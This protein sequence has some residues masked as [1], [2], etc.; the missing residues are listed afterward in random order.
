[1]TPEHDE[2]EYRSCQSHCCVR[3]GCKYGHD[4]CPVSKGRVTQ[5]HPCE[6]CTYELEDAGQWSGQPYAARGEVGYSVAL[7]LSRADATMTDMP[8]DAQVSAA[9]RQALSGLA[10]G[11]W[12]L[13]RVVGNGDLSD[14]EGDD[15]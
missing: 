6:R 9:V 5:D 12:T 13:T 3:H 2:R 11:G 7:G 1:M 10:V 8:T 15:E 4:N 14:D